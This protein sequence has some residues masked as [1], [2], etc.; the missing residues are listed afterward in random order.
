MPFLLGKGL[1]ILPMDST[2]LSDSMCWASFGI[3]ASL[4]LARNMEPSNLPQNFSCIRIFMSWSLVNL[5]LKVWPQEHFATS[6]S[7]QVGLCMNIL[8]SISICHKSAP[9]YQKH[10]NA[11]TLEV[12]HKIPPIVPCIPNDSPM[13]MAFVAFLMELN[14]VGF[15]SSDE[16]TNPILSALMGFKLNMAFRSFIR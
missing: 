8:W 9:L 5:K 16:T 10:S 1:K 12:P 15:M 14:M 3:T 13:P 6:V 4:G 11:P 2:I 7:F